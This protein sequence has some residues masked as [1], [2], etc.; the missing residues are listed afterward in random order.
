[1]FFFLWQ[2]PAILFL[3]YIFQQYFRLNSFLSPLSLSFSSYNEYSS[4][5]FV[6]ILSLSLLLLFSQ[7]SSF[8]LY[9]FSFL[10]VNLV[11]GESKTKEIYRNKFDDDK[12]Q[13]RAYYGQVVGSEAPVNWCMGMQYGIRYLS[14]SSRISGDAKAPKAI[15]ITK[16]FIDDLIQ[17]F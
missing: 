11:Q 5:S 15:M 16:N 12:M 13:Y 10:D 17:T 1:M 14:I 9:P 7:G 3:F 4:A 2:G 6:Y 8:I